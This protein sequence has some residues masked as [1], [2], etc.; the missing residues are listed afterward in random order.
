[1]KIMLN[2]KFFLRKLINNKLNF[3]ILKTNKNGEL[4][5]LSNHLIN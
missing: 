4:K 3:I 2:Y 1:M 5:H